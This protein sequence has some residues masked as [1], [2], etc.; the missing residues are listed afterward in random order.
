MGAIDLWGVRVKGV[1]KGV[2]A[3]WGFWGRGGFYLD[4]GG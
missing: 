3:F 4:I 2:V 1:R